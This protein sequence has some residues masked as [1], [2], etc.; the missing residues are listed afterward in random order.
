MG[1]VILFFLG[2]SIYS[3]LSTIGTSKW[4]TDNIFIRVCGLM[5]D[6]G[7][8]TFICRTIAGTSLWYDGSV[9]WI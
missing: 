5:A 7:Q 3:N 9:I 8:S 6:L 1:R 4:F 2:Y